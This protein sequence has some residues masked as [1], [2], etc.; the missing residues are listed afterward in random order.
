MNFSQVY[1]LVGL[2]EL[3]YAGSHG[4]DIMG[5]VTHTVSADNPSYIKSADYLV[6]NQE[7]T[8][9][10]FVKPHGNIS[11]LVDNFFFSMWVG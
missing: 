9:T 3:Y 7:I 8:A 10:L 11:F 5:P 1:E 6:R 4:M 2:T